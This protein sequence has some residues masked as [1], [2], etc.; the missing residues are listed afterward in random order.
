VNLVPA[1]LATALLARLTSGCNIGAV[2][3][4]TMT[5]SLHGRLW[6]MAALT[7]MCLAIRLRPR[8]GRAVP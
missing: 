8:F 7:G 2:L 6:L 4:G 1:L 5:G 3:G